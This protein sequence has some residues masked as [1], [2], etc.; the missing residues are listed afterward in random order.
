M[1]IELLQ[2]M[3]QEILSFLPFLL[4]AIF[5]NY[6]WNVLANSEWKLFQMKLI[7]QIIIFLV[8]W[9]IYAMTAHVLTLDTK[10]FT[11]YYSFIYWISGVY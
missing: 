5:C 4:L 1:S 3:L 2:Y 6:F 10:M 8:Q 9:V 7:F 11:N